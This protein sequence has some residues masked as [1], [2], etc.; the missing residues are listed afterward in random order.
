MYRKVLLATSIVAMFILAG[1]PTDPGP[2]LVSG[3]VTRGASAG[4]PDNCF[5]ALYDAAYVDMTTSLPAPL[6]YA[7]VNFITTSQTY[8]IDDVPAGT[9]YLGAFLGVDS[10][11]WVSSAEHGYG[12]TTSY[13]NPFPLVQVIIKRDMT[14]DIGAADWIGFP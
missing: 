6:Y 4:T 8:A 13:V 3:T 5:I 12:D 9:Y 11:T 7:T 1:C 10:G 2:Y 14:I